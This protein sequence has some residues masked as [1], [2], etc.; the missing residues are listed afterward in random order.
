MNALLQRFNAEQ[1]A[2]GRLKKQAESKVVRWEFWKEPAWDW[3]PEQMLSN[4]VF[5]EI[6]V[7]V[8]KGKSAHAYGYGYDKE[9]RVVVIRHGSLTGA[10]EEEGCVHRDFLRY[11]GNKIV[12]SEFI[13]ESMSNVFE[14]TLS[15]SRIVR[16]EHL[17]GNVPIWDWK[18]F[19]WEGDR[20][21]KVT[22]GFRGRKPHRQIVYSKTGKVKEDIDLSKPIKR[23]PL[24]KGV[25]LKLLAKTIRQR[26][27]EAVVQTVTKARIKEPVYC[28]A[29]NYD[30]EG[31]PLLLP[32]LGIGLDSERRAH[33][34]RGGR[35]AKLDIWDAVNF[36]MFAN[37]RTALNDRELERA[38]DLFN[39]EMEYKGSDEPARKLILQVAAD[40]AKVSWKGKLDTTDD[41]IVYAVDTDGADLRR[42][43]KLTVSPKQL[44]KLKAAKLL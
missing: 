17:M 6:Q 21:A 34:K 38:C 4:Q 22:H 43:L 25:T 12:G 11:A 23:K 1:H 31:N 27:A 18:T 19:D 24:P 33:L 39:R 26:L 3:D 30:S 41:F 28:L 8:P 35:D 36:S 15:E 9:G 32:E 14:A 44:A 29:L 5:A 13:G 42:N 10:A 40:L 7:R 37:N 16:V 2:F 20:V